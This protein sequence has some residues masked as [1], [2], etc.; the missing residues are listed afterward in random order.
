VQKIYYFNLPKI[1]ALENTPVT[2]D[3]SNKQVDYLTGLEDVTQQW[4]YAS[5]GQRFVNYLID[6]LFMNYGLGYLSGM[7]I[8]AAL[9]AISPEFLSQSTSMENVWGFVLIALLIGYVNYIIYYTLCE[10]L[11]KGYTLGKLV[12]GTR[13]VCANGTELSFRDC[14]LRSLCRL[15]PFEVF[16]G[17]GG[18][19][20]HD[21]WTNTIVIKSR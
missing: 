4:S 18:H 10:K 13:A 21:R 17:F 5:P 19:P 12:S 6:N 1:K 2:P 8:G 7:V 15:V 3:D 20:W 16:S 14:I 9:A 11:F